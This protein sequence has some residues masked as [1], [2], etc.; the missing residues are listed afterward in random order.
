MCLAFLELF[1][2]LSNKTYRYVGMYRPFHVPCA[3]QLRKICFCWILKT[4]ES[5]AAHAMP[6]RS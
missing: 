5:R 6:Y 4:V 2:T 1:K 3:T